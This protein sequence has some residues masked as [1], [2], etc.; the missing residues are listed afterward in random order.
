MASSASTP[1]QEWL[2]IAPD[3][4]GALEKRLAVRGEH[5]A[6]LKKDD[7]S[8]WLWGG[9]FALLS[10]SCVLRCIVLLT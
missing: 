3:F 6:G 1:P 10:L 5:L 2:V 9:A 7:E 8:F 4:E